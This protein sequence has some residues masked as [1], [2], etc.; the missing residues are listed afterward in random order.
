M[1]I[2]VLVSHHVWGSNK[3]L[4]YFVKHQALSL[5]GVFCFC[6]CFLCFVFIFTTE[7]IIMCWNSVMENVCRMVQVFRH[8]G[9]KSRKY[10]WVELVGFCKVYM[11]VWHILYVIFVCVYICYINNHSR[12]DYELERIWGSWKELEMDE[13]G[14]KI[15]AWQ[16]TNLPKCK[17]KS[18]LQ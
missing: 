14:I 3:H 1:Q 6:F 8:L 12:R 17:K 13:W 7:Q 16:Y 11:Y 9:E 10:I 2:I 4:S 18:K 15:M 5:I